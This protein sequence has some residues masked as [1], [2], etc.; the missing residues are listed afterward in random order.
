MTGIVT[1]DDNNA[2]VVDAPQTITVTVA[3]GGTVPGSVDVYVAPGGTRDV[4]FATNSQF[5]GL[6]KTNDGGQWLS[7]SVDGTGSFRF[8]FPYRVHLRL[9]PAC[10]PGLIT[11][12]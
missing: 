7:L 5:S 4:E 3:I 11:G 9:L 6:A 8:L 10:S 2:G 12:R 1:V